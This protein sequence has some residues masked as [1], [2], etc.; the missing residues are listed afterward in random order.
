MN[1]WLNTTNYIQ[2]HGWVFSKMN[3]FGQAFCSLTLIC[4]SKNHWFMWSDYKG[5][6]M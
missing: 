6:Q 1:I 2:I 3:M 4:S 5:I